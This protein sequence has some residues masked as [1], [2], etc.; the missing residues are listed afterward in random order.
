MLRLSL[1]CF[2]DDRGLTYYIFFFLHCYLTKITLAVV[3]KLPAN[4]FGI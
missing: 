3:A 4:C 1:R 2:F